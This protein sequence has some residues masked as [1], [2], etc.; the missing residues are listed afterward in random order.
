M[1]SKYRH[2]YCQLTFALQLLQRQCHLHGMS[3]SNFSRRIRTSVRQKVSPVCFQIYMAFWLFAGKRCPIFIS[4]I[5]ILVLLYSYFPC[6][7]FNCKQALPQHL[8]LFSPNKRSCNFSLIRI[9]KNNN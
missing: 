4:I 8:Q 3:T 2:T 5:M 7:L 6:G 1:L 9:K